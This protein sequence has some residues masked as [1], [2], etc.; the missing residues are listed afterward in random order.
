MSANLFNLNMRADEEVSQKYNFIASNLDKIDGYTMISATQM[1]E[2]ADGLCISDD[3]CKC[4]YHENGYKPIFKCDACCYAR[5]ACG[6]VDTNNYD[7]HTGKCVYCS[8]GGRIY[9]V[10][11]NLPC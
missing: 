9:H 5:C 11:N 3:F 2:I 10:N 7:I 1:R 8:R 6:C 4:I